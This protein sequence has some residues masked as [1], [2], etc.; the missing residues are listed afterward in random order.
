MSDF[1]GSII[2]AALSGLTLRQRSIADNLANVNTP[3]YLA[4]RS[5]FESSL[6]SALEGRRDEVVSVVSKSLA[7][8]RTDGNNVDLDS[9]TISA[10]E[11]NLR[12]QTLIEAMNAKFRLIRTAIG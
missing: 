2:H 3:G 1:A 10:I 4:S 7:P 12:Y 6:R 8:T 9:E 11:T 5:D